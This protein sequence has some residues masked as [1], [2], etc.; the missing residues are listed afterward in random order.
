MSKG[1]TTLAEELA[2][3]PTPGTVLP[4]GAIVCAA[5]RIDKNTLA[6]RLGL[7]I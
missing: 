7:G 4:N 5:Q 3:L 6:E 2:L 1:F